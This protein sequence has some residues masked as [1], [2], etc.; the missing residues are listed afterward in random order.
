MM[1]GAYHLKSY[2][3]PAMAAGMNALYVFTE[4][5][6]KM[7]RAQMIADGTL[8]DYVFYDLTKVNV[9]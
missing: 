2:G 6:I 9:S 3:N 5:S 1:Y 8:G 7:I 4:T